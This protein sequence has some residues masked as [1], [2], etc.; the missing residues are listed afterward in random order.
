VPS[1][2]ANLTERQQK[3]FAT[4]RATLEARTGKTLDQWVAVAK[5]CPYARQS[6]RV[7]W[8]K[9]E[10]GLGQNSAA[11]VLHEAFPQAS[12]GWDDADGLRNAL[13][14]DEA[15]RAILL[16]VTAVAQ[17][18]A[19]IVIGQRKSFTAFSRDVQFAAMRP[20]RGK[21]ALLG[22]KLDHAVSPR[23]TAPTRRESWSERLTAVLLLADAAS[24]DAEAADLFRQ[25]S[26]HG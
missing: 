24:F 19:G 23:L 25:A 11:L 10:H 14:A 4:M 20:V 1:D 13:W 18:I 22:L 15:H 3:Y 26:A 5:A 16:Q 2:T 21:G 9:T 8:L 7:K 6:D 17:D 12:G